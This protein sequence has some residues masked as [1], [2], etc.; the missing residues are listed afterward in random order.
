MCGLVG[1]F[2][3]SAHAPSVCRTTLVAMRDRM[4]ARGPDGAGLWI[5]PDGRAGFGHRRLSI[6]DPSDAGAQPMS[7]SNGRY[8]I[9]YNGEIYNYRELRS[10][11]ADAGIVFVSDSDTEVLL[12]LY[13]RHG[14]EMLTRLRG[15]FAI[16]IWD[17]VKRSTF[18]ARDPLGI[19]PLYYANVGGAVRFASQVKALLADPAIPRTPSAAGLAGFH[20]MGSVP[21]PYTAW[22]AIRAL[23]AGHWVAITPDG[24]QEPLEYARI[25][26]VFAGAASL[27]VSDADVR[28]ALRD[29]V[30]HH[31]VADVEVGAF[32]SSGVDS[33][34]LIGLMRDCGQHTIR[35]CTLAFAEFAGAS[36]DETPGAIELAQN[37]GVDHH[38]RTVTAAEFADDMDAIFDAMDQPSIDGINTWFVSKAC[39]EMGLKV[40]LSGLGGDEL[41]AGYSTFHSVPRT[42]RYGGP[43]SRIPGAASTARML[44]RTLA[45]R[46]ARKNPKALG[47]LDYAGTWAGAYFL[48]RA[49][50][51]PFELE[52]AMDPSLARAGLEELAS[53]RPV[54]SSI[55]PDPGSDNGRVCTLE[56]SNYM[57]NQLLRDS[58]WAGMA[59]SIEIRV[60]LVDFS[61]LQALAPRIASLKPGEGKKLLANAPTVPVPAAIV[62]RRKTGFGI[63]IGGWLRGGA[64]HLEDRRTS[65]RWAQVVHARYDQSTTGHSTR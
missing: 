1:F 45:P 9:A 16:A 5:A 12:H 42:L 63:P 44:I 35:A 65:R 2:A 33:G 31:L 15:M 49:V 50:L 25:A 37:Y 18:L 22:H 10:E 58:D 32:L 47:V 61:L 14:A 21:E 64:E 4:I 51:L 3:Y 19:K 60:P 24:V 54:A 6:I 17:A 29:S 56:L 59:H 26:S 62:D 27:T 52:G 46:F 8:T 28:T 39:R 38:I 13:A 7:T 41:L 53:L 57:R 20:L 34:A 40:A 30:R 36:Q 23:P 43:L 55:E 48:R 11:L